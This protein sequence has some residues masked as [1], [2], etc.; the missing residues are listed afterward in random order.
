MTTQGG[1]QTILAMKKLGALFLL[2][3]GLGA[4][5]IGFNGG[6]NGLITLGLLLIAGSILL[7]TLKVIRRNT[8]S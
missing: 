3:A 2:I 5:A 8:L 1:E 6:Y 7:L 4:T